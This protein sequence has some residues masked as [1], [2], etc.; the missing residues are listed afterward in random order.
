MAYNRTIVLSCML[1]LA[2]VFGA[3]A[4]MTKQAAAP[5][6]GSDS[7]A[8]GPPQPPIVITT[9]RVLSDSDLNKMKEPDTIDDNPITRW[10][11]ARLGIDPSN[12]WVLADE[13]ALEK[14][15]RLALTG[16]EELPDVLLLN[17]RV[18]P[19]MLEELAAS[20]RFA[21]IGESFERYASPR[22]KEAYALNPDVWKTVR[23]NGK[24]WG[25]PQ[26]SDGKV[27]DPILWIRKDWL[28]RLGLAVPATLNELT[29][30][31][32]AFTNR[33]PDGNGKK[34][35]FGLALGGKNSLNGWIGDASF[36]FG[37]Y[38]DQPYQ[39]NR[40][41]DGTLAYG[42]VQP[43][44][45]DALT[46]LAQWYRLGYLHP[47]F[48]THDE[49]TA[50]SLFADGQAGIIS[51]PG[52][53]GG[54]PLSEVP[55]WMNKF[56]PIPFP[57]G[58]DGKIGRRG[59]EI[60]YGSYVFRKGFEHMDAVFRYFDE[61][62]GALIEDPASDFV[63]GFAEN[64]DYKRVNGEIVYDFPGKTDTISRQFLV[65]LGSTP[66][67]VI[68]E[69]LEQRVYR[70]KVDTP[71]EKKLAA[72]SSKLFLEGIIVGDL[73][74]AYARKNEFVGAPGPKMR[75]KWPALQDLEKKA[76]LKIVYG[77]EPPD[78]FIAFVRDWYAY[79]GE[80]ITREVNEWDRANR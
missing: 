21:D 24:L 13:A 63:N 55:D 77:N 5:S 49:L 48:G 67:G 68:R 9:A 3:Y 22:L 7:E 25:L 37:A 12:M 23:A 51:A 40:M 2:L 42:S 15:L 75:A 17:N 47:N 18:L 53:M 10:S 43:A 60:S 76:F 59:S 32:D 73:Q 19:R 4:Y 20:G 65:A 31:L 56:K 39:W 38:G 27:G 74:L 71:Y 46:V 62:Y 50:S 54:W 11:K 26:I 57:S 29:A 58:P 8:G 16:D 66:P 35:T 6:S 52:W 78:S 79:G 69:S 61:V 41:P 1:L 44:M 30:V 72:S 70:G 45:Q 33:D 36:L 14:K 34:D 64:Y 28:D 80:E